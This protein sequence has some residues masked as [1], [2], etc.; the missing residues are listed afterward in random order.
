MISSL[1][2]IETLFEDLRHIG[3]FPIGVV[4]VPDRIQGIAFFPGGAGLWGAKPGRP[5]PPMP[6]GGV[7]VLGHN[8]DS[9]AGFQHSLLHEGEN[10]N[11]P[12][13]RAVLDLIDRAGIPREQCFF[14]NA[15]MGLID[16]RSA[17]GKF[18]GASDAGFVRR[19]QDFLVKQISVQQPKVILTLGKEVLPLLAAISPELHAKWAKVRTLVAA[20]RLHAALIHPCHFSGA[21]H[22]IA[23]VALTHPAF[24]H[25]NIARRHYADQSGDA[26]EVA[27][28]RDALQN[29]GGI[30]AVSA[31]IA[32]S[33]LA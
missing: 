11:G 6:I 15:Y 3:P 2:P 8:F 23:V 22:P 7:M 1:H 19:C 20:D 14:T 9:V 5:L 31:S 29:V 4:P 30:V 32:A 21:Q 16:G 13:W 12:T 28:I 33:A 27:L 10:L 26:A 24:R 18:P 25:L 17:V